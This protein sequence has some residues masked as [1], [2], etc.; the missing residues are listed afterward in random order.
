MRR[1][2]RVLENIWSAP[3]ADV[4]SESLKAPLN[5]VPAT[6]VDAELH[7]MLNRINGIA[8]N[9]DDHYAVAGF[10]GRLL[11]RFAEFHWGQ[12]TFFHRFFNQ[13]QDAGFS[14]LPTG[15]GQPV[16]HVHRLN[17]EELH[18]HFDLSRLVF[19]TE[20]QSDLVST[21]VENFGAETR[22]PDFGQGDAFQFRFGNHVFE[23]GD[24]ELFY[25]FM[26]SLRPGRVVQI[27]PG[28]T[29][30]LI[31]DALA[32]NLCK[33]EFTVIET[34]RAKVDPSVGGVTRL[35]DVDP[36][37]CGSQVFDE[38]KAGD[39]L[40]IDTDHVVTTGSLAEYVLNEIIP[41][42]NPGVLVHFHPIFLPRPYP[43]GWVHGEHV[44]WNEQNFLFAFLSFN[45]RF[46]VVLAANALSRTHPELL[47]KLS[48]RYDPAV[49]DPG[50]FWFRRTA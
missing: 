37:R 32:H 48:S 15:E 20:S 33:A 5:E 19:A 27:G 29:T 44:F 3:D 46:E 30:R 34:A 43:V 18:R 13:W 50:G 7:E 14:L 8:N 24:A 10:I 11:P 23:A 12:P 6:K 21:L 49:S 35:I 36:R 47:D 41:N 22:A 40:V 31:A 1:I 38:L 39:V 28:P 26:R 9:P 2:R 25:A 45:T 4:L 17:Q 16:P 42:L